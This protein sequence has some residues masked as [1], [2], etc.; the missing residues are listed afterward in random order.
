MEQEECPAPIW[1]YIEDEN[2]EKNY[3]ETEINMLV[4]QNCLII[5]EE[6]V[7]S[8]E[9]DEPSES[10]LFNVICRLRQKLQTEKKR[11]IFGNK[12]VSELKKKCP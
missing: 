7:R 10:Q 5:L 4:L 6:V 8:L 2:G 12:T 9:K 1:K 11:L 3:S